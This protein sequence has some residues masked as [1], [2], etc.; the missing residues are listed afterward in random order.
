MPAPKPRCG[1]VR[2]LFACAA[3]SVTNE[4]QGATC[5]PQVRH[6]LVGGQ[7][8]LPSRTVASFETYL[9]VPRCYVLNPGRVI[10]PREGRAAIR[11]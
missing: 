4:T 2:D 8:P 7:C 5:C 11:S 9:R 6:L 1:I 10:P 3:N